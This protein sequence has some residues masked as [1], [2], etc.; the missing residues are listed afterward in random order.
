MIQFYKPNI[1]IYIDVHREEGSMELKQVY[2]L[3]I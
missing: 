1:K 3:Q 2:S